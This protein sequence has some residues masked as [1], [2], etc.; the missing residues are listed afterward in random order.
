MYNYRGLLTYIR[1]LNRNFVNMGTLRQDEILFKSTARL[2]TKFW[3]TLSFS[4]RDEI[5]SNET[6]LS[7]LLYNHRHLCAYIWTLK[8]IV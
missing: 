5:I 3:G 1:M 2:F 7:F 4:Y 8:K 6:N